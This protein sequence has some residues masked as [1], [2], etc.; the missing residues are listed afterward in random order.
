MKTDF[1]S[2]LQIHFP[3]LSWFRFKLLVFISFDFRWDRWMGIKI[4][5]KK[6]KKQYTIK[7]QLI[8]A[9]EYH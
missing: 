4:E 5:K 6:K 9:L 7:C 3:H 1:L 2:L 8:A